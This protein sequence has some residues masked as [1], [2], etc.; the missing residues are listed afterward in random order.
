LSDEVQGKG[1]IDL[2]S[3]ASNS[4]VLPGVVQMKPMFI[5][6]HFDVEGSGQFD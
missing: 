3:A 1:M 4:S 2:K 6:V 5:A